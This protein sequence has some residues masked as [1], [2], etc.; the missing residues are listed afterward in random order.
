MSIGMSAAPGIVAPGTS[1]S[2]TGRGRGPSPRRLRNLMRIVHIA[3][4]AALGTYVYLPTYLPGHGA[5]QWALMLVV[6]PAVTITGL[7]MWKQA[8]VRRLFA[9]GR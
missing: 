3:L 9:R 5:Y 6:V 8:L 1:R 4:G 2:A 7:V